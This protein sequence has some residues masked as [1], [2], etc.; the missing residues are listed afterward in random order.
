M[1][2]GSIS[3]D[4]SA[5]APISASD[6]YFFNKAAARAARLALI[7]EEVGLSEQIPIITSFLVSALTPWLD[8]TFPG[9]GLVYDS[10]WGGLVSRNGAADAVRILCLF[11]LSLILKT[12]IFFFFLFLERRFWKW[13]LQ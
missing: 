3:Q 5:L 10:K 7:A 1:K 4:V 2:H 11:Q 9:N 13:V 12:Q 8:G 6:S